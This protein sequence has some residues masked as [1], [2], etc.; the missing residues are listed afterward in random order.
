M[1]EFASL[2][3]MAAAVVAVVVPIVIAVRFLAGADHG[4]RILT[5]VEPS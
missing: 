2:I 4:I 1:N 3:Q 5:Y